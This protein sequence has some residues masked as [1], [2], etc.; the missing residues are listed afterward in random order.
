M[1]TESGD[2]KL[3]GN[4]RK[5]IDLVSSDPNYNPANADITKAGLEILHTHARTGVTDV[6]T[7]S[8][9][10]KVAVNQCQT[11]FEGLPGLVRST[12][13]MAKASGAD[14]KI[15]DDLD[16][17]ARKV[18]GTRKSAKAKDDPN[19]P[20][21]EAAANHSASQLS[22]ENQLGNFESFVA[23]LNNIPSYMPN[24]GALKISSLQAKVNTLRAKHEAVS[25]AFV[26]LSQARGKRDQLLYLNDDCVVNRALLVKAYVKAA[27]GS[28]SQLY[29]AIKGLE[30]HRQGKRG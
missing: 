6:A 11:E 18:I 8:A 19:T 16:T 3:L 26:P 17:Y 22:R 5:L 23:L 30:F 28:Q 27:F 29:K 13:S 10:H 12:R 1:P 9:P 25:T 14:K 24:E 7:Q 21:N 15:Q 2:N 4:F 20:E